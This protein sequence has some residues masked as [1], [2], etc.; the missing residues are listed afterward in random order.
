MILV[1]LFKWLDNKSIVDLIFD[2][3]GYTYGPL[4]GLFAFG[5]LTKRQLIHPKIAV[6][7]LAS[8]L[9]CYLLKTYATSLLGTYQIG[10]ELLILNGTITFI[11]LFIFSKKTQHVATH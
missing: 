10:N 2:I 5:I 1:F 6:I 3:A 11:L 8:P 9:L 7:S 4:L